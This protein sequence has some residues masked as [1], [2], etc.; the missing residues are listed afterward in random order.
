MT[1]KERILLAME[2]KEPDMVPVGDQLIVSKVASE[3]LGRYAYTGG[4]EFA[5]DMIELLS[6]NERE[7]L[8]DRYVEDTIELHTKLDFDF[9]R[10]GTVPSKNFY[11]DA[12]PVK[13]DENIYKYENKETGNYSIYKFSPESGEFFPV[14]SSLEKEGFTALEREIKAIEKLLGDPITFDD[15]SIFDGWDRIYEKVGKEKAIAFSTGISIPMQPI[16]LEAA[17]SYPEWIDIYLEYQTECAIAF[18]KEAV[19]HSADFI[20]GGGDLATKNGPVYNPDIFRK[21]LMP[22]YKRILDVSHS[23]GLPYFYRSDGNTRP[24]W[25]MWFNEI[26][27][28]GYAEIDAS[29]GIKL[30]ELREK[31]G[32]RIVLAGN[33]DCAKTLVSVTEEEIEREVIE[34]IR[35]AGKG[36]GLILTSSNSIHYNIPARNLVYMIESARKYGKYPINLP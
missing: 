31:Y 3:I 11:R 26:G 13:I 33:V 30:K 27:F 4:G 20:L 36:G 21:F 2:H 8:V 34:C 35:D 12:L 16:Y 15:K 1:G 5:R 19:K 29:A 6:S 18:I 10:V 24:Y 28:D 25:D 7:F 9:I 17:L 14:E 23:V 22:R 32:H